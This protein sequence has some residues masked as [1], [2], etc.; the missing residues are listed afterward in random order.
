M[1]QIIENLF[2]QM[3]VKRADVLLDLLP[4]KEGGLGALSG[5]KSL[6][7]FVIGQKG[8]KGRIVSPRSFSGKSG[9]QKV[10]PSG[11]RMLIGFET[12]PNLFG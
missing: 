10:H 9:P 8:T 4:I 5:I 7:L 12:L 2:G 3:V 6:K 11:Q 1:L